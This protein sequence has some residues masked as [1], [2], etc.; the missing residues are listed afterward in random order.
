MKPWSSFAA[1][2]EDDGPRPLLLHHLA[3]VLEPVEDVGPLEPAR[4][5]AVDLAD[6]LDR[7]ALADRAQDRLAG[8]D[9]ERVARDPDAERLLRR[10]LLARRRLGGS[11]GSSG[12]G[13]GSGSAT[14]V[15]I[16]SSSER[17]S[18]A[19]S[20]AAGQVEEQRVAHRLQRLRH[21]E[22]DVA[23]PP[24]RLDG[25]GL[26]EPGRVQERGDEQRERRHDD[27]GAGRVQAPPALADPSSRAPPSPLA[28][29]LGH[30][31]TG[32]R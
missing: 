27:R 6:R 10:E 7:A 15:S 12:A 18:A 8:D 28:R 19:F 30:L 16:S 32:S 29:S 17:P 13:S 2:H 26:V 14:P 23:L 24:L 25:R 1:E 11:A 31:R 4:D 20:R 9:D 21:R 5:P 22:R 3:H